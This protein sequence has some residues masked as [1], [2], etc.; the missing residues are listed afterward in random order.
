MVSW[1]SNN[2]MTLN[3]PKCNF[4]SFYRNKKPITFQYQ[5]SNV[6]L[7]VVLNVT[8]LG[9]I[10]ES[11][12]TFNT[13][14]SKIINKASKQLGFI[15]RHCENFTN[16]TAL[17]SLYCALVRSCLEYNYTLWAPHQLGLIKELEAV[18]H[19]FLRFVSINCNIYREAHTSYEPLLGIFNLKKLFRNKKE[20]IRFI[21]LV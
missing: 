2:E 20:K 19:R 11:N 14:I 1:C 8:D 3:I 16:I 12:L 9:I 10:F 15:R 5:I 13:H 18:Q 6:N 4:I 21:F 17:K 7:P